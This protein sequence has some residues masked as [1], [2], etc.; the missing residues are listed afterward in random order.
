MI[1]S[2]YVL[3]RVFP[4]FHKSVHSSFRQALCDYSLAYSIYKRVYKTNLFTNVFKEQ[5][6]RF[7]DL[8]S[9]YSFFGE[10]LYC[11]VP[12]EFR[13]EPSTLVDELTKL[14]EF[15]ERWTGFDFE[16]AKKIA[17]KRDI[18]ISRLFEHFQPVDI[19]FRAYR[20]RRSFNTRTV[21]ECF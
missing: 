5:Y 6:E 19:G 20:A 8:Y 10:V 17:E 12:R 9:P 15:L 18:F 2:Q 1:F 14:G 7:K 16:K 11:E 3:N 21:G 4:S 13:P